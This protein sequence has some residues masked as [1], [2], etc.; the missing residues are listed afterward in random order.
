MTYQEL[1][2]KLN[3]Y[4]LALATMNYDAMTIAPKNGSAYRQDAMAFLSGE[5]FK[6]LMEKQTEDILKETT[7]NTNPYIAKSAQYLLEEIEKIKNVPY[8]EYIAFNKLRQQSQTIWLEAREKKSY[9]HFQDNFKSLVE[10]TQKMMHYRQQENSTYD[11]LLSDYEKGLTQKK[12]EPFFQRLKEELVP[13]IQKVINKQGAKP[14]FLNAYVPINK[15]KEITK[16][17]I[18]Y[19]GYHK[20]FGYVGETTHPFSLTFSINDTRITTSYDEYDFTSNIFSVIH[21]VGH[22]MYNHQVNKD[23]EGLPIAGNMSMSLHESQSRFLENNIARSKEFWIP[24]YPKLQAIIP[25]VLA[26]VSL[27]EFILGINYVEKGKIRTEADELTYPLHILVRYEIEKEIFSEEHT[28][29]STLNQRFNEKMNE[30]LQVEIEHDT[31]GFLQ[32]IH[33]ADASFGYFP[34][35]ALGS[36]YAAQFY[37]AMEKDIPIKRQLTEGNIKAIFTWLEENIHQY[38]GFYHT[39]TILQKASGEDFNPNYFIDYLIDKYSLL[40]GI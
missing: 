35:Y 25:Q 34:S 8:E 18:D 27:D 19:L 20:D 16:L 14:S 40:L 37:H 10:S 13:F 21:E 2:N 30:Y 5:H 26:N 28:D 22:S 1:Q 39:E 33:W 15:Q 4:Q 12:I 11:L 31:E 38:G 23:F 24:I 32:D 7:K 3:A 17:I 29:F 36:A 6:L 9:E